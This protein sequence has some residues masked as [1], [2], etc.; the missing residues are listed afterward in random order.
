MELT[1]RAI[2]AMSGYSNALIVFGY[3]LIIFFIIC[4]ALTMAGKKLETHFVQ[5]VMGENYE[6]A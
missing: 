2:I 6:R 5:K 4:H 1:K 3:V